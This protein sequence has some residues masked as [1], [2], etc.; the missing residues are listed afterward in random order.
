MFAASNNTTI[1]T[2]AAFRADG[3]RVPSVLAVAA[4]YDLLADLSCPASQR[5]PNHEPQSAPAYNS[6]SPA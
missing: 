1:G 3:V 5:S 2:L 4:F 6:S